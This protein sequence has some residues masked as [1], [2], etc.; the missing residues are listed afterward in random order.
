[1]WLSQHALTV[2]LIFT[3]SVLPVVLNY[4]SFSSVNTQRCY[5]I[6]STEDSSLLN[7]SFTFWSPSFVKLPWIFRRRNHSFQP[8]FFPPLL[9]YFQLR[10][11]KTC[12]C[13]WWPSSS[14]A[15]QQKPNQRNKKNRSIWRNAGRVIA[16]RYSEAFDDKRE[17][18][19]TAVWQ[20]C[21]RRGRA[22][23]HNFDLL[24]SSP[25][26]FLLCTH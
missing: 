13:L 24:Q 26:C 8:S 1:M 9:V 25:S 3:V 6:S 21:A 10:L 12:Q 2:L 20:T 15:E 14:L 23:T 11:F 7:M 4:T 22:V 16:L 5:L 19:K 17:Y 18:T